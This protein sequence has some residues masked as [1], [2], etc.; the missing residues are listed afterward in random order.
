[1]THKSIKKTMLE[2]LEK[3]DKKKEEKAQK[4][5]LNQVLENVADLLKKKLEKDAAK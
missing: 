5:K 2:A 4:E 3:H 1:M